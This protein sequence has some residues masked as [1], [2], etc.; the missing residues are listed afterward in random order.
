MTHRDLLIYIAEQG[1]VLLSPKEANLLDWQ[2]WEMFID[3]GWINTCAKLDGS[4]IAQITPEGL[5]QSEQ[6]IDELDDELDREW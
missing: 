5:K 6:Y 4:R 3:A 2:S 1:S